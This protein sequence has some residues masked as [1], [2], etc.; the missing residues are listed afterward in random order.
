LAK[1]A[2]LRPELANAT[3][4]RLN[5]GVYRV[6]LSAIVNSS[7]SNGEVS[8][9]P[10][11]LQG[12]QY[13]ALALDVA[14]GQGLLG[15]LATFWY[16]TI[17]EIADPVIPE[18]GQPSQTARN[19]FSGKVSMDL[20]RLHMT[21]TDNDRTGVPN[22]LSANDIRGYHEAY[23]ASQGIPRRT[24]GGSFPGLRGWNGWYSGCETA[25]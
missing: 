13:A 5:S 14:H 19:L 16:L 22:L 1:D 10:G 8:T 24:F 23:F 17:A 7:Y 15:A 20:A 21:L 12:D 3:I 11:Q 25:P 4:C 9:K 6:D 2:G 18:L